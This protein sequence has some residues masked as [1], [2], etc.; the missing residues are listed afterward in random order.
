MRRK[1]MNNNLVK[2]FR[3]LAMSLALIGTML[4]GPMSDT[5]MA[6]ATGCTS[7]PGGRQVC[8]K[9]TGRGL[10]VNNIRAIETRPFNPLDPRTWNNICKY[11]AKVEVIYPDGGGTKW[12]ER[13]SRSNCATG[14]A[15]FDWPV[16][17]HYPPKTRIKVHFFE[18]GKE[19][20]GAPAITVHR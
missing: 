14:A 13:K 6:T 7:G 15:W 10:T 12:L 18:N 17:A 20:G 8:I 2:R 3:I 4:L 5:A 16:N 19:M 9:V 11:S 1:K